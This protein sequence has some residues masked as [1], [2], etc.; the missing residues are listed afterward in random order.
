M[1]FFFDQSPIETA[2]KQARAKAP[3]KIKEER[4]L[5][6]NARGCTACARQSAW[7]RISSACM[8]TTGHGNVLILGSAPT[9]EADKAGTPFDAE[10][11]RLLRKAIPGRAHERII[12]QNT[13]R[14]YTPSERT[15]EQSETHACSLYLEEDIKKH[16][17]VAILGLG[18][19]PLKMFISDQPVHRIHGL[20][21]PVTIGAQTLWY[22]PALHPDALLYG[23]YADRV[24]EKH[25]SFP[26]FRADIQTFFK[27]VDKWS[28]PK[29]ADMSPADVIIV[30]SEDEAFALLERMQEPFGID[31][32]TNALR[33]HVVGAKIITA[34][35]SDGK[36]TFAWSVQ[37]PEGPTT[38]GL[39][40][41]LGIVRTY[42]WI[43]HNAAFEYSWFQWFAEEAGEQLDSAKFEDTMAQARLYY[44]RET[45]LG[46]DIVSRLELGVDIKSLTGVSARRIME[47]PLTEVLPY[48]GLD[49]LASALIYQ[50]LR[51]KVKQE[52]Y[53]RILDSI[54]STVGMELLGLDIDIDKAQQL[55]NEWQQK[56]INAAANAQTLYEVREFERQLQKEWNIASP[57]DVGTALV[58][59]GRVQLPRTA[60]T[61][62]IQY[63]TDDATLNLASPDNPLVRNVLDYRHASKMISTYIEPCISAATKHKDGLL[64]PCYNTMLTATLRLSSE[65]PNIQNFPKRSAEGRKLRE[66]VVAKLER[67][68]GRKLIMVSFDFKQLEARIIAA[69]SKDRVL[70]R[71]IINGEDMHSKWRDHI[72]GVHPDYMDRLREMSGETE[73]KKIL[74]AGRDVIKTDFVF[75]SFYGSTAKACAIRTKLPLDIMQQ[76]SNDFWFD[77][78]GVKAWLKSQ[79]NEYAETGSIRTL[80][81]LT[82][83]A[84]LIGNEPINNPVQGT[85]GAVV[86]EAQNALAQMS[87][88]ESDPFLHPRINI[89][90]DL[91][92]LLPDD[93]QL[94]GYIER[95]GTEMVKR[96]FPWLVVP[97]A[98][99]CKIG[100]DWANMD[101]VAEFTGEYVR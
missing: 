43:A 22:Y 81:G 94:P 30:H 59:Y 4:K 87:H 83:H 20:R 66:M 84:V 9:Y 40:L 60:N 65:D 10:S 53:Q 37:H 49:A 88:A 101:E 1:G 44:Q 28:T 78:A 25:T 92:F 41:L 7:S 55:Q 31:I 99:E 47:Y 48:N 8:P 54:V 68:L 35:V 17:V 74:K 86:L 27:D 12:W 64:H 19:A 23:K 50:R 11:M 34:A 46:L 14:C 67:R 32:E 5:D 16:N 3:A 90:D 45:A 97:L 85:A 26:V 100:Y 33:P 69:A 93:A 36:T 62:S 73:E 57:M 71:N 80:T 58:E 18:A 39:Q 63:A 91:T 79:R 98:V 2:P 24:G 21:F 95:I 15:P 56:S 96:R 61:K 82:R 51:S 6:L 13:V 76:V 89:H 75:A 72:L 52:P 42:Q 38:W 77:Y 29:V 70:C